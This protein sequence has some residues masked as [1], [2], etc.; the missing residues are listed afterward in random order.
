MTDN[1]AMQESLKLLVFAHPAE[2]HAFLE[3]GNFQSLHQK[4]KLYHS[5]D[6]LLLLTGEGRLNALSATLQTLTLYNGRIDQVYNLGLAGALSSKFTKNQIFTIKN[7]YAHNGHESIFQSFQLGGEIDCLTSDSRILDKKSKEELSIHAHLVDRELWGVA[8][9]AKQ[10]NVNLQS[11]KIVS[12]EVEQNEFCEIIRDEA[13][14]F[15]QKLYNYYL[16]FESPSTEKSPEINL[17]SEFHLTFTLSTKLNKLLNDL[18]IKESKN[19]ADILTEMKLESY[20]ERYSKPK[21]RS[22]ALIQDLEKRLNP[23]REKLNTKFSNIT[24]ELV[25]AGARVSTDPRWENKYIDISL[26]VTSQQQLQNFNTACSRL[27]Y[28]DYLNILEGEIE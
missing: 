19:E 6:T 4:L 11:I 2:A 7:S 1:I 26:R 22:L 16:T 24:N 28:K 12:D 13:H 27:N 20:I 5:E 21:E 15:S 18:S 17:P 23:F 25:A 10:L 9:A 14:E 8:F 3:R